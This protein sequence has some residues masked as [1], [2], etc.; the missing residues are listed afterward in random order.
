[1]TAPARRPARLGAAAGATAG[2]L[3]LARPRQVLDAA[4][5][6]AGA[7]VDLLQAAS[8]LPFLGPGRYGRA[9]RISAAVALGSA[10]AGRVLAGSQRR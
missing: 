9:A 8:M 3:L 5:G 2:L 6:T 4:V 10:V 1:M 7:A